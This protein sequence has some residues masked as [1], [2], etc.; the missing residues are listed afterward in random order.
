M[1]ESLGGRN[2]ALPRVR[3][4]ARDRAFR[5]REGTYLVEGPTLVGD[6]L[7]AGLG[8]ALVL[9]P[10]AAAS[11]E[12][13]AAAEDADVPC[14][15]VD[16]AL[17][18]GLTTT[19]SPQPAL[20]VVERHDVPVADLPASGVVVVLAELADPGNAG[21]LVRSAEAFGAAGVVFAGGVDP[22]NPKCVRATAGSLFRLP[23]AVIEGE[24]AVG[25]ALERLEATGRQCWGSVAE[26]G[27]APTGVPADRSVALLLGNEPHGLPEDILGRC[28][29]LVSVA[30]TG[31][32]ESLNVA[33]AGSVLLYALATR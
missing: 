23:F 8:V 22:Y 10:A 7:T 31:S 29:G 18:D 32:G 4:L 30:T 13:V 24:D 15:L 25:Q 33:V 6:A 3:R 11:S 26:G 20:A 16:A 19:R 17:F 28:D 27:V 12:V 21:T 14:R 2:P 9:V 1:A 5:R